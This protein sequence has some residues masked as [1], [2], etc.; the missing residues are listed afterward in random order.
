[1]AES[2]FDVWP[3]LLDMFVRVMTDAVPTGDEQHRS[4]AQVGQMDGV[5]KGARHQS[6][7]FGGVRLKL[8]FK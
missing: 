1:M 5:M 3:N 2:Q 6:G 8:L 7:G 4:R